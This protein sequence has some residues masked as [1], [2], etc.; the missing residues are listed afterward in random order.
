MDIPDELKINITY[1][2]YTN[3]DYNIWLSLEKYEVLDGDDKMG[4]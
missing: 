2:I 4:G 1:E 3:A